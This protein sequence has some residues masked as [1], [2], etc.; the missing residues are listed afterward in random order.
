MTTSSDDSTIKAKR[1]M[2]S[3]NGLL[4]LVLSLPMLSSWMSRLMIAAT[5]FSFIFKAAYRHWALD[6][7]GASELTSGSRVGNVTCIFVCF[8]NR[9]R[10]KRGSG[11]RCNT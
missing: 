3:L 9:A 1:E 2:A 7:R 5:R 10:K 6:Y 11:N 4:S 8:I